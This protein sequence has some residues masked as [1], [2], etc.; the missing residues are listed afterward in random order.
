MSRAPNIASCPHLKV[1][2]TVCP[3]G[4]GSYYYLLPPTTTTTTTTTANTSFTID[5]LLTAPPPA[6]FYELLFNHFYT[7]ISISAP[8]C[9]I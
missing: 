8:C 4:D 6:D 5:T 2:W 7:V 9:Q 3:G 1:M